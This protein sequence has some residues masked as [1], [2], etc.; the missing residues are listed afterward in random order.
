MTLSQQIAALPV[1]DA[2]KQA[3]L[4]AVAAEEMKAATGTLAEAIKDLRCRGERD[5]VEILETK[6]M[7]ETIQ[8]FR[9]NAIRARIP[10]PK[11]QDHG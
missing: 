2:E 4:D 8:I 9:E 5:A 10:T 6:T 3:L 7:P 1:S 11:G